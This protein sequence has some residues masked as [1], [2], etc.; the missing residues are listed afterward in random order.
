ECYTLMELCV[1]KGYSK[2][3]TLLINTNGT[4]YSEKLVEIFKSFKKV[5]L[6]FSIDDIEARFEY[7]R[8]GANWEASINNIKQYTLAGGYRMQDKIECKMCC[9]V[10]SLNIYY[11]PEYFKW[12]DNTFPGM[13]VYLNFLHGPY[14]LSAKNLPESVKQKVKDK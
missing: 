1:A 5:L 10:S 13:A 14:S 4:I 8:K 3:I 2:N 9:T 11:L 7:Q 6:N 12:M